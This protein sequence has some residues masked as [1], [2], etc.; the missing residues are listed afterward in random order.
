MALTDAAVCLHV[1]GPRLRFANLPTP[2]T[3]EDFDHA[4]GID[5]SLLNELGTCRWIDTATNVLLIGPPG[6]G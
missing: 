3:L 5:R 4:Q 6:T 2:A 1:T